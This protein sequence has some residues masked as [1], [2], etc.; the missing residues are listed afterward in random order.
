MHKVNRALLSGCIVSAMLVG[1]TGCCKKGSEDK[2]KKAAPGVV[3]G[4]SDQVTEIKFGDEVVVESG[5][6]SF[7][8]GKV[9]AVDANKVTYEYGS[10]RSTD[11]ADK[12][13]VYVIVKEG[14]TGT[15]KPGDHVICRSG[16]DSWDACKVKSVTGSV[17][18]C[19]DAMGNSHNLAAVDVILPSPKTQANI[20]DKLETYA[21]R[22]AFQT[23]AQAA[24]KPFRPAGFKPRIGQEVVAL[25]AGSSWYGG[26]VTRIAQKAT[27]QW[28]DK[29][30]PSERDLNDVAPKPTAPMK[31][32]AGQY[33]I[34]RPSGFFTRWEFHKVD[35]VAGDSAVVADQ[36]DKKKTVSTKDL[37]PIVP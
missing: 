28:D 6:A 27:V 8:R 20:K 3:E 34:V 9:V 13:D 21:R 1:M 15:E 33:V 11:K 37:I 4:V 36:D 17:Y 25:F 23:A 2:D 14:H 18:V 12:G 35:S 24:G 16:S 10:N 30:S 5:K 19:D 22:R 32:A 7:W 26:K 29:S 31:V